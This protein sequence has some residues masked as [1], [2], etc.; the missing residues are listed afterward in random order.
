MNSTIKYLIKRFDID[1]SKKS[2]IVMT[3]NNR[4]IMAQVL[5]KLG[6]KEGAEIGVAQGGHSELLCKNNPGVKLHAIDVWESYG[7]YREYGNRIRA[8]Y[9]MARKRLKPYNVN[10]IKKFSMDAVK[11]FKDNSLDFVF[12]DGAHD[13]KS[14]AMDICEWSKKVRIGGIVYGHDYR[15]WWPGESRYPVHVKGVVDGYTKSHNISPWF[16]FTGKH[17]ISVYR[18]DS[19]S[20]MF[21]RQKG[22]LI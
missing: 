9:Q 13:F 12:I 5:G 10:I 15:K 22:D 6:F 11:D 8:Y 20:W 14:V 7:E 4:V 21:V 3:N 19:P 1:T 18:H 2:P 17:P 16:A